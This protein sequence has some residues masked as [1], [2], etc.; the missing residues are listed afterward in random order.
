VRPLDPDEV[1]ALP[2]TPSKFLRNEDIGGLM[3]GGGGTV[4]SPL[5]AAVR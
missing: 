3:E 5:P 1:P 4:D 2:T